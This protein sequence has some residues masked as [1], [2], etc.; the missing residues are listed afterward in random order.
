MEYPG[1][2]GETSRLRDLT[3]MAGN[4]TKK[5][6]KKAVRRKK[7]GAKQAGKGPV[8]L[9]ELRQQ[10]ARLVGENIGKMTNAVVEEASKGH[11][12]HYKYLAEMIGL[13]PAAPGTESE[14]TEGNDLAELLLKNIHFPHRLSEADED[15]ETIEAPA[16]VAVGNDSVE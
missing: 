9:G 2:G 10:V 1:L 4:M 15:G 5:A 11:L 14:A 6:A 7:P 12:V 13:Y 16:T 3:W 8:N